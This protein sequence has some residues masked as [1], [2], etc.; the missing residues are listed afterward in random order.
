M[1]RGSS[2]RLDERQIKPD[3]T[4]PQKHPQPKLAGGLQASQGDDMNG[5]ELIVAG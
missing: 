3:F 2:D 1:E 5:H 4:P